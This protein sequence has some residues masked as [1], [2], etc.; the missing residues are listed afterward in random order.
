MFN[1][2][3]YFDVFYLRFHWI[4]K[5]L[6]WLC[7]RTSHPSFLYVRQS[8]PVFCD[9]YNITNNLC[10]IVVFAASKR[11]NTGHHSREIFGILNIYCEIYT[12]D[13]EVNYRICLYRNGVT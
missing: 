5:P 10:S 13:I 1:S 4:I 9:G 8:Q 6:F 12:A 7:R 2:W 11:E 3:L